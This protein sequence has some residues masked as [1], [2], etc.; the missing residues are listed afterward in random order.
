MCISTVKGYC[1]MHHTFWTNEIPFKQNPYDAICSALRCDSE[2]AH[3]V[4]NKAT[5]W[6]VIAVEFSFEELGH[7]FADGYLRWVK[8][9][10]RLS[11][12]VLKN[13]VDVVGACAVI[14]LHLSVFS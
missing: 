3:D 1:L 13:S 2:L 14:L 12:T 7:H 4:I 9:G 8:N 6:M 5:E 10:I 11:T